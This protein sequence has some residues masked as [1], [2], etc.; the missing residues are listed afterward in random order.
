MGQ[1]CRGPY[2]WV[3]NNSWFLQHEV[4]RNTSIKPGQEICPSQV[5]LASSILLGFT[6][7]TPVPYY[8]CI[9][10]GG[11]NPP[12]PP[13]PWEREDTYSVTHSVPDNKGFYWKTACNINIWWPTRNLRMQCNAMTQ[14]VLKL[15][16]LNLKCSELTL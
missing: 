14:T 8:S 7:S 12:L 16:R 10:S 3:F 2:L 5:L 9:L 1:R 11:E 4:I 6:G 13:P 15:E